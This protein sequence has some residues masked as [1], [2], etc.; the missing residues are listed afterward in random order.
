MI[1]IGRNL[2]RKSKKPPARSA[3]VEDKLKNGGPFLGF[4]FSERG[5]YSQEV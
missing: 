2:K 5:K 3:G 4:L 1:K